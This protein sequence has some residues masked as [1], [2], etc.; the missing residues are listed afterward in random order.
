M[1]TS[2]SRASSSRLVRRSAFTLIEVLVVVAIIALL[3]AILLPALSG[4][5]DQA[6]AATCATNM[7]QAVQGTLI[8]LLEGNMRKERVSTNYGWAAFSLK[9]N[10][11]VTEIFTCPSDRNP[12]P[13]PAAFV[14]IYEGSKFRGRVST[15][16]VFNEV[17]PNGDEYW[18]DIQDTVDED[19]FARD[20]IGDD[21][22]V[23]GYKVPT[24]GQKTADVRVAHKESDWGFDV[25]NHRDQLIWSRPSGGSNQYVSLPLLWM[26]YGANAPAGLKNTKGNPALVVESSVLGVFPESYAGMGY[27][28]GGIPQTNLR[29]VLRFRHGGKTSDSSIKDPKDRNYVAQQRMNVGFLDGHVERMHHGQ[30]IGPGDQLISGT[31]NLRWFRSLWLGYRKGTEFKFD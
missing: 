23:L 7:K 8:H 4:A 12:K 17:R 19:G 24:K 30:M 6:R 20:V 18:C 11:N 29:E 28:G 2:S 22:L 15:D 3:V 27:A 25:Y 5:R 13:L 16:G 14:R 31:R 1:S 26:S 10:K 9:I 21:D